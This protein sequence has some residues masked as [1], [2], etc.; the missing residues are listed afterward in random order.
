MTKATGFSFL[1]FFILIFSFDQKESDLLVDCGRG[2]VR[3]AQSVP[4]D[5]F[6]IDNPM[7]CDRLF[8]A[9]VVMMPETRFYQFKLIFFIF[10]I[11]IIAISIIF[12]LFSMIEFLNNNRTPQ[13]IFMFFFGL[14][15]FFLIFPIYKKHQ[16]FSP[17]MIINETGVILSQK[18]HTLISWDDVEYV[19]ITQVNRRFLINWVFKNGDNFQ[20]TFKSLKEKDQLVKAV[21]SFGRSVCVK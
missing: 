7:F 18:D 11:S 16:N 5:D 13:S 6:F 20:T 4:S 9:E 1:N 17:F 8:L 14:S 15:I 10:A 19:V 3:N 12:I 2:T 21:Q